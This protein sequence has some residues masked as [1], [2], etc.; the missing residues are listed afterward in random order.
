[1]AHL[2]NIVIPPLQAALTYEVPEAF[3]PKVEVG[4]RVEVPLGRRRVQGYV[5]AT[6]VPLQPRRESEKEFAVKALFENDDPLACFTPQQ[7]EFFRWIADY[8]GEPLSNV[9]DVAIPPAPPPKFERFVELVNVP[10]KKLGKT[11]RHIIEV[12]SAAKA[13]LD[14]ALLARQV[15]GAARALK[16]LE[17]SGN[18]RISSRELIDHH[19][20]VDA[21]PAWAKSAVDLNAEQLRAVQDISAAAVSGGFS[22]FVL[23]GVT[24]SG[25]TEVYIEAIRK[26]QESGK[27]SLIIVPE[28]ALTPQLIDRFRARLGDNIA[29]LH[30]ALHRRSRWDAWRALLEGRC[31]VAIG[32]RS[33]IF[34]PVPNLGLI[35]VDEEHESSYKQAEGLRYHARDLAIVRAKL[36]S[37]AVVLGSATP[38]LE[39]YLN[40]REGK[41]RLLPLPARHGNAVPLDIK[42][43]DLNRIKPWE[44][45]SRSISPTLANAID[46][47]LQKG[48]QVFLLYNRRGFASYLQCEACQAT[49]ECPNCS[50]T[51]TFHKHHNSLLC[52]YCNLSLPTPQRCPACSGG[53]GSTL[54]QRGA[55]TERIYEELQELFP[56]A[57]MNRLDRDTVLDE[58]AYRSTLN[59]VREGNT[60]ILV[61]TQMIAKGHDL[62]G[63]TLVGIVDCDVGLHM[64]DFRAGE[65]IF[66]LLTQA[67][68]RAGRGDKPG[69]VVLQTRVPKHPSIVKTAQ[70][71]FVGFADIEL[72]QRKGL[73]YPPFSRLLRI[74]VSSPDQ[75]FGQQYIR[76]LRIAAE[77]SIQTRNFSVKILG[78]AVAPI[79]KLRALWRW[80]MILKA[81][82]VSELNRVMRDIS[83][84]APE[85]TRVR[86][87]FDMD[88]QDLM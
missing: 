42:V 83:A 72:A 43:V 63:V 6:A 79:A 53:E 34:A 54:V 35:I 15:K 32:A 7:L 19:T 29:V 59:S 44:M 66:Q 84:R 52:H 40:A 80:H 1:M 60:D 9:I 36:S 3:I 69:S 67:A 10:D 86:L 17:D 26:A 75:T 74:V 45:P 57:R 68:G 38:S 13:P 11:Q 82:S 20:P 27:G 4:C 22:P 55:G 16:T 87:V 2:V 24:G 71:D 28:I 50:V 21:V 62:P 65:R 14:A 88:P 48:E 70:K 76:T 37:A 58:Q 12:L 85:S 64:P 8:Y 31:T 61:G 41:Y 51:L 46:A 56:E 47:A 81:K 78:P 5:V 23:H 77:E 49:I 25:K 73:N 18:V 33:G 39:T 30:S